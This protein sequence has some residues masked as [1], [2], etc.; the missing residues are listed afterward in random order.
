[1]LDKIFPGSYFVR[2]MENK[3][4][5]IGMGQM[6][7][8]PGDIETNLA[9]AKKMIAG[10]GRQN[11]QAVVLPEC[12]DAGWTF[13]GAAELACPIPGRTTDALRD[14]AVRS[15]VFVVAG[16]TER[17]DSRIFNAAVLIAP[18]GKILS[19]HRKINELDIARVIY[20]TGDSVQVTDTSLGRIGLTI[21][22]DNFPESLVFSEAQA[23]MGAR[24]LLSPCAWAVDA[25]HDDKV[26]PYGDLW[27]QAYATLTRKYPVSIIGVSCVGWLT[28]GPWKGRKCIGASLA[29]GPGGRRLAR[30]PYG[31][32]A[33]CLLTVEIAPEVN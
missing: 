8:V 19:K 5:R 31:E 25:D 22:A 24:I 18:D 4:I 12:L 27:I 3:S 23:R 33:E 10:A 30:G 9:S 7:V 13:S 2:T 32:E 14:A 6:R 21:C 28:E 16:V 20:S 26:N 1:M 29:F 11:C 15:G 17:E